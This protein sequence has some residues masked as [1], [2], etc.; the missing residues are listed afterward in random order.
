MDVTMEAR[1]EE[2]ISSTI[3]GTQVKIPICIGFLDAIWIQFTWPKTLDYD[4]NGVFYC[5]SFSFL[6]FISEFK[7][8]WISPSSFN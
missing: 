1:M 5:S 4:V 7:E 3:H 2:T 8:T 6:F